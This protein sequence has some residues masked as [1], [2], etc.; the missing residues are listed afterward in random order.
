[1][2]HGDEV[3]KVPPGFRV[4]ARADG[5]EF[6]AMELLGLMVQSGQAPLDVYIA[7]LP[8]G[9]VNNKQEL[10]DMLQDNSQKVIQQLQQQLKQ[11]QDIMQQMAKAYEKTK[12][13]MDNIDSVI[14]ENQ[15]LKSQMADLAAKMIERSQ[16]DSET[17]QKIMQEMQQVLVA[18]K[19]LNKDKKES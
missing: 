6:S 9:Y 11:A 7:N 18:A 16:Q 13:D 14:A 4:T 19:T 5:S 2:S 1:M 12:K 3:K 8:D 17:T 15:R 10:L